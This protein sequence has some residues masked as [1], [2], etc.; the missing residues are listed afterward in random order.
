MTRAAYHSEPFRAFCRSCDEAE[1]RA[2]REA[3]L[4]FA[5]AHAA[6]DVVLS[7]AANLAVTGW[8]E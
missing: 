8:S 6:C 3:A 5:E 2:D 1:V 4:E 7:P